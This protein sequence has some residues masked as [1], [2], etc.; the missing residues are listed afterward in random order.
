MTMVI[1]KKYYMTIVPSM[2]IFRD[3]GKN[4]LNW[5]L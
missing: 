4:K 1:E 5:S 3:F 2:N